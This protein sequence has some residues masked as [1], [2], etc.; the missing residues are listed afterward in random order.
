MSK[1]YHTIFSMSVKHCQ[2]MLMTKDY[3][4]ICKGKVP[5]FK[6]KA[7]KEFEKFSEQL[8]ELFSSEDLGALI[9]KDVFIRSLVIKQTILINLREGLISCYYRKDVG[10]KVQV[11]D[12]LRES[13]NKAF[14]NYPC[15]VD[16]EGDAETQKEQ[17]E[18][19]IKPIEGEIIRLK[20]KIQEYSPKDKDSKKVEKEYDGLIPY[21]E[22]VEAVLPELGYLSD[23]ITVHRLSK[24][25]KSAV[26]K[27]NKLKAKQ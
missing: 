7:K 13:Y 9:D 14:G 8:R 20:Y 17:I 2:E 4:M 26:I 10:N 1:N 21:M 25:Y 23:S 27:D 6:Y 19:V 18:K 16:S 3:L 15:V 12:S 11:L 5:T 24:L 22:F